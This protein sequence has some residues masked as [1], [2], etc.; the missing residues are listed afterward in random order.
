MPRSL[1][2][3]RDAHRL[4]Y[5]PTLSVGAMIGASLSKSVTKHIHTSTIFVDALRAAPRSIHGLERD[6]RGARKR[7][8]A[9]R[10]IYSALPIV[11]GR[12][13]RGE[14]AAPTVR[15]CCPRTRS[16]ARL[17]RLQLSAAFSRVKDGA[18]MPDGP[19]PVRPERE[20][21]PR[22]VD[23]SDGGAPT[24]RRARSSLASE[25]HTKRNAPRRLL[26][27]KVTHTSRRLP[28]RVPRLR[29]GPER[30]H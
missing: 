17:Q 6:T 24:T 30:D 1:V 3:V 28:R 13:V 15:W 20:R 23:G 25:T 18:A 7:V 29:Q 27:L 26:A 14:G 2:A 12:R 19:Q 8:R 4:C 5:A 10:L 21:T 22:T 16:M 11:P 9:P